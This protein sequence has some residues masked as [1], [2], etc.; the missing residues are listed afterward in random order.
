MNDYQH[1]VRIIAGKHRG[2]K[3]E[4]LTRNG[5]RPTP[6]RVRETVFNWLQFEIAQANVLDA[7]AGSG[8]MGLEA[9]SR[10]AQ[11]VLFCEIDG[12]A[13]QAIRKTLETWRETHARVQQIDILRLQSH[14]PF[15]L[16]ILDP[17]FDAHLYE[18][19]IQKFTQAKW[20]KA[21]GKIY[22][23]LP[24]AHE[25]LTLPQGWQ[26]VKRSRAGHIYFGLIQKE[27]AS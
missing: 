15:D 19:L 17:P 14:T 6:N 18:T 1:K 3:V 13:C 27:M 21:H 16:I 26:W 20:I 23:E 8:A 10:G 22:L 9:L 24:F 5:L 7:C 2:R 4:V 25:E 12:A 11:S